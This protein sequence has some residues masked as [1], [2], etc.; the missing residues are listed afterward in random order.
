MILLHYTGM[1]F[2]HDAL[3]RLCDAKSRVSSHYFVEENGAV[4]QLVPEM[5]RA[6]HAGL[7][8]WQGDTDINSR[9][10]G[11]EIV[12]RGHDFGYPDFPKRQIA[13]VITLCRGILKRHPMR[14]D[15]VVGHSDV[16]PS[17]KRDPGEKF[18]WKLLAVSGVGIWVEPSPIIAGRTIAE[19]DKGDAVTN[20]QQSLSDY[21]F[22]VTPN[23]EYDLATKDV[24]T[25]FQ[26]HF[27][28]QLV[29]GVADPSTLETLRRLHQARSKALLAFERARTAS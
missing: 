24:V 9:S 22:G 1:E 26:R 25:A 6:W 18:P 4:V 3:Y 19:G 15:H 12:N 14:P 8:T 7:S 5:R 17:R 21:G 16:A 29:D 11:I 23:G 2:A 20:L 13:A 10:I 28:P 27:R